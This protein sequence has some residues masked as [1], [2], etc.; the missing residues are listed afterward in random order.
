MK[1]RLLALWEALRGRRDAL[2]MLLAALLLAATFLQPG[3]PV[4]RARMSIRPD[5]DPISP[6]TRAIKAL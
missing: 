4:T 1:A 6:S 3:L 5:S 2:L